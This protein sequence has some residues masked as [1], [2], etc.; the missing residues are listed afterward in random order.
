MKQGHST[1]DQ[2]ISGIGFLPV[3]AIHELFNVLG[4]AVAVV[5]VEG[6]FV[7]VDH[8]QRCQKHF[9]PLRNSSTNRKTR[10]LG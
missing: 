5:D 9:A 6:V 1:S 10:T 8:H 4:L 7:N 2:P 3:N